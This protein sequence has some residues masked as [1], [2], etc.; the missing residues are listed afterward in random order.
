[1]YN[2]YENENKGKKD[3]SLLKQFIMK[4]I[5]IVIFVLLLI[6]LVPWPDMSGI[7]PLQEQIFNNNLQAMKEAALTY[8]TTERLPQNVGD[9]KTLTLQEMLDMHLLLP[10]V[11]KN[12]NT[13]SLTESYVTIE[14]VDEDEYNYVMKVNLKCSDKEDY[15]LVYLGCYSYC[16]GAICEKIDDE[17]PSNP[18]KPTNPDKPSTPKPN[19]PKPDKPEPKP[20]PSPDPKPSG[21]PKPSDVPRPSSLPKPSE[22]PN[23]KPSGK[24]I[25]SSNP[26]PSDSPKPSESP[27][28]TDKPDA[29]TYE[30]QYKRTVE[31]KAV[32]SDWSV[33]KVWSYTSND[34]I[35]WTNT[36]LYQIEDL[37]S[38]K[39]QVGTRDVT[40]VVTYNELV[41]T[42]T[43]TY[44]VCTGFNYVA[45]ATTVYTVKSDW[46]DTG[47]YTQTPSK[48]TMR[49]R[50]VPTKHDFPSNC[51]ECSGQ[52]VT[53]YKKQ[54]RD[55]E[56]VTNYDNLSATCKVETKSVDTYE[57]RQRSETIKE[58]IPLYG[59]Q[60]FYRDRTRTLIS[61]KKIVTQYTWTK[62]KDDA[63]LKNAGWVATG[64]KRKVQ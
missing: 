9:K 39:V 21:K 62:I 50:W 33:W 18:S 41:K 23:P 15:I 17:K 34:K 49:T 11:D 27:K 10:F 45:D 42:G 36:T 60:S 44:R 40:A 13:C 12:G 1:M 59:Y 29:V 56:E 35:N 16:E 5:L 22:S 55:I 14:K 31:K 53:T 47:E 58:T 63:L 51:T 48:N 24:P 57:I 38:R 4:L 26:K 37:G 6:W 64:E 32:Y 61:P 28:P 8:Y 7:A 46:R 25:P 52:V 43:K 30:Y 20:S 19:E 54:V 3:L 2:E